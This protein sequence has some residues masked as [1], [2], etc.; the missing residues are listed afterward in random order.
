[1]AAGVPQSSDQFTYLDPVITA[2]T[3]SSGPTTGGR[4]VTISGSD[5]QG[6]TVVIGGTSAAGVK[7]NGKGTSRKAEMPV[8]TVGPAEVEVYTPGSFAPAVTTYTYAS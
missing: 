1:M 5:L 6:A 8:G 3:S 7:V 2:I 4:K